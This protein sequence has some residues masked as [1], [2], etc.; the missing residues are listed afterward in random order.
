VLPAPTVH[1]LREAP[2]EGDGWALV[3]DAAGLVDPIT[4]EGLYYAIH[5]A[6]LLAQALIGK[7]SYRRLLG[8]EILPELVMAAR[9]AS[10]FYHGRFFGQ[11]VLER[12]VRFTDA[13]PTVRDLTRDL[14]AG[15]QGYRGLRR[16]FYRSFPRAALEMLRKRS[17]Q[18][19]G[20]ASL[21]KNGHEIRL[22]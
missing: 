18:I 13:S 9:V 20:G 19:T 4:G 5:S 6:A 11:P 17:P 10:R 2:L 22:S 21:V 1:T 15:T 7:R 3:G 8:R 14:F 12:V 16:R